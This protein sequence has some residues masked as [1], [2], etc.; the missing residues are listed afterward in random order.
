V[1]YTIGG[2]VEFGFGD[3]ELRIRNS[4]GTLVYSADEKPATVGTHTV[5]WPSGKWNTGAY[6]NPAGN[7]YTVELIGLSKNGGPVCSGG[8]VEIDTR[9]EIRATIMDKPPTGVTVSRVSGLSCLG[10][11]ALNALKVEVKE[12]GDLSGNVYAL[13]DVSVDF[14]PEFYD[15]ATVT[16]YHSDFESLSPGFHHVTFINI[17]DNVG[18]F[19]PTEG[20]CFLINLR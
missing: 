9:L 12:F 6:A 11:R 2:P 19:L 20:Q 5:Q 14:D 8:S 17:R 3:V 13:P 7:P 16:L 4:S 10:D 18:N 15:T 1:T